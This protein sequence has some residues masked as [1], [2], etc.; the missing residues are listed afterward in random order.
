MSNIQGK[1]KALCN[2]FSIMLLFIPVFLSGC[3]AHSAINRTEN[4]INAWPNITYT[5][6]KN[7]VIGVIDKRPY[8]VNGNNK[9]SY[10]GLM[11]GGF[12]NPWYMNTESGKPLA[13]DLVEA[14][15]SGFKN[16]GINAEH[17]KL[18]FDMDQQTINNNLVLKK[19]YKKVLI[20]INEWQSDTYQNTVF[21]YDLTAEVYNEEGAMVAEGTEKNIN[22]NREKQTVVSPIEA[23]RSALSKLLNNKEIMAALQ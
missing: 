10:I 13:D 16:A 7:I 22:E 8:I 18:T 19:S 14:A 6:N 20:K 11:R 21:L 15:A 4:Y 23:S 9:P 17:V 3:G 2:N 12:N 1:H 5:S